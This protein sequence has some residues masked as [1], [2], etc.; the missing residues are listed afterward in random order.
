MDGESAPLFFGPGGRIQI[1]PLERRLLVDGAPAALGARAFDLLLALAARPGELRS[2][3][4]LIEAVWPGV[5]IEEGN[6]AT[7]I[8][9]LRKVLG[10]EII[11]TIPGRGY[12]FTARID[13]GA[14][15]TTP[16][17]L[18]SAPAAADPAA[19]AAGAAP[20]LRTNLPA[21]LPP[22]IGRVDDLAALDKLVA[23]HRLVG[24]VGAGG[25]GKTRLAQTFLQGCRNA[26]RHGV[27]W[28]ELAPL[29]QAE[30]LPT[31]IA[32]ALGVQLGNGDALKR[33]GQALAP[34][35]L[36]VALDNA[37]HLLEATARAAQVLLDAAP[38]LRLVVTSQ[39]PLKVPAE[40]VYRLEALAVP[41]GPLPLPEALGYGALAL[42][43]DR[44]QAVDHRFVLTP[45]KLPEVIELC[46]QLDGLPLAI[47]LAAARVPA[48]GVSRLVASMQDRLK[49]LTAS[50]NRTA[51][52]RQQTLR[53]TLE[54]SH[55]FLDDTERT[56]FRRL[57]VFAGSASLTMVQ[58]VV[59]DDTLDEWAA[60]DVLVLL[61]ERSLVSVLTT[62]DGAEPRYRLL[63]T[64][65][66]YALERLREA[67]EEDRL[68]SRHAQAVAQRFAAAWDEQHDGSIGYAAWSARLSADFD[69]AREALAWALAAGDAGLALQLA[70]TLLR[71]LPPSHWAER[72]QICER[73][74]PLL[75]QEP[76]AE[77]RVRMGAAV[78]AHYADTDRNHAL[79]AGRRAIDDAQ[80]LPD[81]D[82]GQ[83]LRYFAYARMVACASLGLH[84]DSRYAAL[85]QARRLENPA[86]PPQ[87]RVHLAEAEY[88]WARFNEGPA[89][90]LPQ[91]RRFIGMMQSTG[92]ATILPQANLIDVELGAGDAAGAARTGAALVEALEG[93]RDPRTLAF[94]RLNLGAARLALDDTAGARAVLRAGWAQAVQFE[95]HPSYADY[96]F[97]LCAL[98]AHMRAA[99]LLAGY[100]DARNAPVGP[101]ES[102]EA[103]AV[104]RAERL[105]RA[106]LGDAEFERLR[107]AGAGLQDAEIEAIAFASKDAD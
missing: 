34:L 28:V 89:E 50:R 99:A 49:L 39:A 9:A 85:A 12:R 61:V 101:R 73:C 78:A 51:P 40:I 48:F 60:L 6:L 58:R 100:S 92:N 7:Q 88:L 13:G 103:A 95:L 64:P 45:A 17:P 96:L 66:V 77:L 8:S 81:D 82:A 35:T 93:G 84:R 21:E 74:E 44:A 63:D 19:P 54:W 106:A 94:A 91:L 32:D 104:E 10:G 26:Y 3:N 72:R 55:G 2:K 105:A 87:R 70:P 65:R 36:L 86:W 62:D 22:L 33:L 107:A 76:R 42:F 31:A 79:S 5:V 18:E 75:A 102:N 1:Q 23:Q 16:A 47:E 11:A 14:T 59:A 24:I 71:A 69:N 67:G 97:L 52:A 4:E 68:R 38:G 25:I 56:V 43:A 41:P 53:A 30:A 20:P 27:C 37:E 15:D 46:R 98:E 29:T 83:W 90:W 57:A 80:T